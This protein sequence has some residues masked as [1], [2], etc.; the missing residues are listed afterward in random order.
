MD[1]VPFMEIAIALA[2][3]SLREGN[4]GFGAVIVKDGSIIAAAHDTEDTDQDPTAHAEINA[5]RLAGK[6]L[7]K[8]LHSCTLVSTHE[9]CPMCAAA[10]LWAGIPAVAYGVSIGDT[11]TQ[12]RKRINLSCIEMFRRMGAD[13]DVQEGICKEE[14]AVLYRED[15]RREIKNLRNAGDTELSALNADSIRRRTEWF[16]QN[17]KSLFL[18]TDNPL[19]A[20]YQLLLRRLKITPEEAPIIRRSETEIVFHSMNF[21]PTLQACRI[22]KL[23]TRYVCKRLNENATDTLLKQLDPRLSFARNYEKL[24]PYTPYCEEMIRIK[25]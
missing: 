20:G 16:Q 5:I 6:Q 10:I 8:K 24:R 25:R 9:P 23:D 3:Q 4:N 13:I 17:K 22:L 12:G 15:V 21:C 11:I 14:C 19:H 2:E 1:V 7:G 18:D